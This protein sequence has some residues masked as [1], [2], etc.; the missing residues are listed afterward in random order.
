MKEKCKKK[1]TPWKTN[2][3]IRVQ[4]FSEREKLL[5]TMDALSTKGKCYKGKKGLLAEL[6]LELPEILG[7]DGAGKNRSQASIR[8]DVVETGGGSQ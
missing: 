1:K 8:E 3:A 5:A 7:T 2:S 6:K 4:N